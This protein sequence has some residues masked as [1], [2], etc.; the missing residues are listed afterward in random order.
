MLAEEMRLKKGELT[1]P[2]GATC[3]LRPIGKGAFARV[4]CTTPAKRGQKPKVYAF[5]KDDAG[6][7][8]KEIFSS[9]TE[10][11]HSKHIPKVKRAGETHDSY[12]YEMPLYKTPLRREDSPTAW[13]QYK[14]LRKCRDDAWFKQLKR[15]MRMIV[16]Q[17]YAI[18]DDTIQ[19]AKKAKTPSSLLRALA[20][21]RD[22]ASNYGSTYTFEFAPRNLATDDK[23]ALILLDPVYDQETMLK[24]R[25]R[26][27]R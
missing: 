10:N 14:I 22:A 2:D 25:V 13:D 16:Y 19:C 23:G 3:T 24:K 1:L 8:S 9:L 18:M 21:I 26:R 15:D 7:Y 12:V 17:G 5:I 11:E 20:L 6:D 27:R 4:Y